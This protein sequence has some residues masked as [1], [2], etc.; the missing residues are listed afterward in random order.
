MLYP[1]AFRSS[2]S[3]IVCLY[4]KSLYTFDVLEEH[5][6]TPSLLYGYR[7]LDSRLLVVKI[8]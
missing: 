1:N 3:R 6:R 8:F 2:M 5:I 4:H 7:I